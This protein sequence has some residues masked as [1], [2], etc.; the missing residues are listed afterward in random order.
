M[1]ETGINVWLQSMGSEV[2]TALLSGVTLL[3]YLPAYAVLILTLA[4]GVRLRPG[5]AVL[6]A[7]I[8]TGIV[9]EAAKEAVAFPRPDQVDDRLMRTFP[10]GGEAIVSRGGAPGFW[11]L[12]TPAAIEAV[13]ARA[14]G[15]SPRYVGALT[16]LAIAYTRVLTTGAPPDGGTMRRPQRGAL[17]LGQR[18]RH[19]RERDAPE[20]PGS[21]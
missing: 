9:T 14:R 16:G 19:A 7:V 3:G 2:A 1:F 21:N 13:R 4:F 20:S 15:D 8:L 17:A 11:S 6:G 18:V 12:P 5:L 10:S